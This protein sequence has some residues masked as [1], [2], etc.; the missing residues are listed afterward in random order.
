M[1]EKECAPVT[2]PV[3][4]SEPQCLRALGISLP[5]TEADVHR[6]YAEQLSA[7]GAANTVDADYRGTLKQAYEEALLY[8]RGRPWQDNWRTI[9]MRRAE[10][11]Q[12]VI[13]RVE[14]LGGRV[15]IQR[16]DWLA[17]ELD[18][19]FV[20]VADRLRSIA[21]PAGNAD[22]DFIQLLVEN[23]DGLDGLVALDV[24]GSPIGDDE[25]RELR[26]LPSLRHLDLSGTR[27]S[28]AGLSVLNSLRQL[29]WIG[30]AR[31]RVNVFGRLALGLR[32]PHLLIDNGA[33]HAGPAK[34]LLRRPLFFFCVA[35]VALMFVLT[36]VP[37]PPIDTRHLPLDIDKVVHLV[38]FAGL[39]FLLRAAAAA[40]I[41]LPG[42]RRREDRFT[43]GLV[44][45]LWIGLYALLDETTQALVGRTFDW[46]DLLADLG[47]VALG[48]SLYFVVRRLLA[49][50]GPDVWSLSDAELAA[51]ESRLAH[52]RIAMGQEGSAI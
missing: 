50:F 16:V 20:E 12:Q 39:S 42:R 36:H 35:Y 3:R 22:K 47:G 31:T 10:R 30:L 8:V 13:D 38:M 18:P 41:R 40:G 52:Q 44:L 43:V 21:L 34:M 32:R 49:F 26:H 23:R 25:V 48:L 37:I 51:R 15:E 14:Q 2:A 45:C 11:R 46:F 1:P 28:N 9:A 29:D 33:T 7:A 19:E 4:A 27:V 5:A 17:A 24:S 6:A